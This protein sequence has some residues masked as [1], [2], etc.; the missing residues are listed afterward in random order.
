MRENIAKYLCVAERED[1]EATSESYLEDADKILTLIRETIKKVEN[2]Y[3]ELESS[4]YSP[5]QWVLHQTR[6][7][8]EECRQAILKALES[9]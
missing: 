9:K 5:E 3:P 2:P 1:W 7:I 6:L 4:D 8:W